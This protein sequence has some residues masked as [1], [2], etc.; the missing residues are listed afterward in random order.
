MGGV[1]SRRAWI[2]EG[3]G[4]VAGAAAS[5]AGGAPQPGGGG[6]HLAPGYT[7]VFHND[8]RRLYVEGCGLQRLADGTLVA[9]VP[10][11]PRSVEPAELRPT[12]SRVHVLR[13]AAGG[14]PGRRASALPYYS[15][16]P[17][18]HGGA[19]YLFAFQPGAGHRN[20]DLHLLRSRDG[21]V[22]W[23]GPVTLFRGH[24]WNCQTGMVARD[25]R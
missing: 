11:V 20:D 12:H 7:A 6:I 5:A 1:L 8:D 3:L 4:L 16:R 10:V 13:S 9:A 24:C 15:A 19:L 23:S 14:A 25:G 18:A 22:T 2:A 21:G 17:W